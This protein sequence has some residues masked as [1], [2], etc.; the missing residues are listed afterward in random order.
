MKGR[1][2]ENRK[3][4]RIIK[5]GKKERINRGRKGKEMK[6]KNQCLRGEFVTF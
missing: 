2:R 4:G 3:Y 5:K 1:E 6:E